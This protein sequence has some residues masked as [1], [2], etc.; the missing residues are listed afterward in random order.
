ML[1]YICEKEKIFYTKEW[2]YLL[3]NSNI[4]VEK[5]FFFFSSINMYSVYVLHNL[6]SY[7]ITPWI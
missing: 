4:I 2:W 5:K 3:L 6:N 7:G 1:K